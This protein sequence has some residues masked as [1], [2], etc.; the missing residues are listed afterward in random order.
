MAMWVMIYDDLIVLS[1]A[2]TESGSCLNT[3]DL[4][5]SKRFHY[6]TNLFLEVIGK[7]DYLNRSAWEQEIRGG[8]SN[9]GIV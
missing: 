5:L 8:R 2:R 6:E 3:I 7:V 4:H 1:V 9:A